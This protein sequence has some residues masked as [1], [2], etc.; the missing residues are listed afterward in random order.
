M[1]DEQKKEKTEHVLCFTV[2]PILIRISQSTGCLN[3]RI[4][5]LSLKIFI[6]FKENI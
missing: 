4:Q 3:P 6:S 2:V 5:Y 1:F